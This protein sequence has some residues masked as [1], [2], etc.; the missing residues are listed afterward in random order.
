[1]ARKAAFIKLPEDEFKFIRISATIWNMIADEG[2]EGE[3]IDEVLKRLLGVDEDDTP[4]EVVVTDQP[5]R[6]E[7]LPRHT[8][9]E[10][11]TSQK[12]PFGF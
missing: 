5:T 1:M 3:S 4:R 2:E 12:D 9:E 11:E 6:S 10:P 8:H 7:D